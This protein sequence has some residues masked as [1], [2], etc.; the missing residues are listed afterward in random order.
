MRTAV[1]ILFAMATLALWPV[2]AQADTTHAARA[3]APLDQPGPAL[4]VPQAALK[5]SLYCERSVRHARVEP[6]L[7]NPAT[8]LTPS[9]NYGG[10]FEPL[11]SAHKIPWCTVTVPDHTLGDIQTAGEYIVH[12]IR[13]VYKLA[14]RRIAVLGHSQGGMSMRWAL[15][16]WPDTRKMVE[17]V[18]GLAGSNH[19][20][21]QPALDQCPDSGCAAAD[22]QQ[23]YESPFIKALNSGAETFAGISYTEIYTH[24][25]EVVEPN[26]SP[27]D[28][29]SCLHTGKGRITNEAIQQICP[30]DPSEHMEIPIDPVAD[31]L[32][33]D[34]LTHPG[35]ADPARISKSVCSE[36]HGAD[37]EPSVYYEGIGQAGPSLLSVGIG[38]TSSATS[39]APV[40]YS[41]P[42]LDCYVFAS[43]RPTDRLRAEVTPRRVLAGHV[44]R[45][46][47]SVTVDVNGT[48]SPVPDAAVRVAGRPI[49][50]TGTKGTARLRVRF[51]R[52]G[53][54][55]VTVRAR[56]YRP[57]RASIAVRRSSLTH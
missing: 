7:L 8:G 48:V 45:V 13:T 24:T 35:P 52:P 51:K 41:Q 56:E 50:H 18:I 27:T 22:W 53:R 1:T 3:Y 25:D 37:T 26:S 2:A 33:L 20:T 55:R 14:G 39:G 34:A 23:I 42:P 5:A 43:C 30:A 19:G 54:H 9:Q 4:T 44:T 16:F 17:D 29:S 6:V 47:V 57:G 10:S 49:I 46:T 12:A 11:L 40:Y 31:A 32:A 38:A 36:Q 28:C 21:T 15:R